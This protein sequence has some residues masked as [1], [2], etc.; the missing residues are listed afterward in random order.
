VRIIQ[1]KYKK[2][3]R[4]NTDNVEIKMNKEKYSCGNS[5]RPVRKKL[6]EIAQ[7]DRQKQVCSIET[8]HKFHVTLPL[9]F[10][11]STE[12]E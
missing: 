3:R 6:G 2:E 5:G 9:G 11:G 10:P 7:R 1:T 8:L 4:P 12:S